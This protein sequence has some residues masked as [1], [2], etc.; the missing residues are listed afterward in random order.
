MN[1]E[2]RAVFL[3]RDGV[4]NRKAP[5]GDYVKN[6]KEF[7]FLPNV[8]EAIRMLNQAGFKVIVTTNQRGIA[9]GLM[10]EENLEEIHQRMAAELEKGNAHIDKI[11]YCPHE[12]NSCSC[13]K[14]EIGMFLQAKKD[15]PSISFPDSF[16][17]GDTIS[18]ME[19][20]RALSCKCIIINKNSSVAILDVWYHNATSLYNAVNKYI[21]PRG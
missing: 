6:W 19:A 20:G 9:L 2:R 8:A 14:P 5:D 16:V 1:R 10:T 7:E 3:D 12:K 15:Y 18:D 4:I 11:Y 13:R 21:V 17:I